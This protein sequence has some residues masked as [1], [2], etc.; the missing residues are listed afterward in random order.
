MD[1]SQIYL[2]DGSWFTEEQANIPDEGLAD[3][4][5]RPST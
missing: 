3:P 4:K 1:G 2:G 5:V